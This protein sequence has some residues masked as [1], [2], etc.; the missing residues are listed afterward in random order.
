[1]LREALSCNDLHCRNRA[2]TESINKYVSSVLAETLQESASVTIL[3]TR[4][5]G[6]GGCISGWTEQ[7]APLREKSVF[8][9][10]L[11]LIVID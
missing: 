1:V 3:C 6:E 7:V 2:H 5:R 11:W 10:Q 9:H 8:W 4:R